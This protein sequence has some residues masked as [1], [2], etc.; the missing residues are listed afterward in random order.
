MS[1]SQETDT[2][3]GIKDLLATIGDEICK[4]LQE[5]I[6]SLNLPNII[7]KALNTIK[8]IVTFFCS[9]KNHGQS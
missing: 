3:D 5:D 4:F 2:E 1:N 6:D 7:K 9:I 8:V